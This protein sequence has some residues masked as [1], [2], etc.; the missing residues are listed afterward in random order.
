MRHEG[1]TCQRVKGGFLLKYFL[2]SKP[3]GF[4]GAAPLSEWQ[5]GARAKVN[6]TISSPESS[7]AVRFSLLVIQPPALASL[8]VEVD[9]LP[10]TAL[11]LARGMTCLFHLGSL[12]LPWTMA[13]AAWK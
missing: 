12:P 7:E 8:D 2:G 10:V 5:I 4:F 1:L 9:G 6:G 3:A 11:L 13:L